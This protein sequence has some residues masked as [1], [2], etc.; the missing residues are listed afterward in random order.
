MAFFLFLGHDVAAMSCQR[1]QVRW[2]ASMAAAIQK[3][4]SSNYQNPT[5]HI[6]VCQGRPLGTETLFTIDLQF[7]AYN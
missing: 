5:L 3:L 1:R 6:G 4:S 7:E 2:W